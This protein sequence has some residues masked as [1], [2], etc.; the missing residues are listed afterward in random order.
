MRKPLLLLLGCKKEA[1]HQAFEGITETDFTGMISQEDPTDWNYQDEWTQRELALFPPD[2]SFDLEGTVK[3]ASQP[4]D[5]PEMSQSMGKVA[6]GNTG[7]SRVIDPLAF[8]V[9]PTFPNPA[10]DDFRFPIHNKTKV[11]LSVVIVNKDFEV[12]LRTHT[13]LWSET[14]QLSFDFTKNKLFSRGQIYRLY[15]GFSTKEE[16]LFY[17][18]HGDILFE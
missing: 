12:L 4:A 9:G 14:S 5:G 2:S 3:P 13:I 11:G 17:K 16:W 6:L 18:G 7:S 15:Y 1:V 10:T 8:Q